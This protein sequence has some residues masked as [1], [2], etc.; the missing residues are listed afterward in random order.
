MNK[1]KYFLILL[2]LV[3]YS[4]AKET[5]VTVIKEISQ[6]LEMITAYKEGLKGL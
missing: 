2:S 6:D 1:I 5:K 4:C 3:F